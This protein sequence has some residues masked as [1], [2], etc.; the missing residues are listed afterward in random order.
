MVEM[1]GWLPPHQ[2]DRSQLWITMVVINGGTVNFFVHG[3]LPELPELSVPHLAPAPA[4]ATANA[5]SAAT[6]EEA[7]AAT[8]IVG[9]R[10]ITRTTTTR[11]TTMTDDSSASSLQLNECCPTCGRDFIDI[12]DV[13][14]AVEMKD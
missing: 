9:S 12:A 10:T 7:A 5:K 8:I 1:V 3:A 6:E 13:I 11:T 14:G 4:T 2:N